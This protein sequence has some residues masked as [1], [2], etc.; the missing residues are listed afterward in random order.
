MLLSVFISRAQGNIDFGVTAG[1]INGSGD[2][3]IA[4]FDLGDISDDLDVINGGGFFVGLLAE[5]EAT[6]KLFIQPE[7]LYSSIGDEGAI[8]IPVMAKYYI[9]D[10]FN[11]QAGPQLDFLTGIPDLVKEA[12][13]TVGFSLGFGAGYDINESFAVQAKYTVGLT[14]RI[15]NDLSDLIPGSI[16]GILSPELKTDTFQI[17]V[18]YKFN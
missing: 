7:V 3:S 15:D 9:A 13:K 1:F 18:V 2:I 17:G 12:I 8:I 10:S 6:E 11:L 4:G 16:S 5:I 14:N